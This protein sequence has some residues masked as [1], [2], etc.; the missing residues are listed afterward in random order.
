LLMLRIGTTN[1]TNNTV[2]LNDLAVTANPFDGCTNFH[3]ITP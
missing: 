2:A 1:H 3:F